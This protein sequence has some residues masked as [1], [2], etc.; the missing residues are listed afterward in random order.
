[1]PRSCIPS[2]VGFGQ[3]IVE[4]EFVRILDQ[5]VLARIAGGMAAGHAAGMLPAFARVIPMEAKLFEPLTDGAGGRD[6][7]FQ[8]DPFADDLGLPPNLR[9]FVFQFVQQGKRIGCAYLVSRIH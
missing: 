8:R 5:I 4:R 6:V 3:G 7:E 9:Q 1:M 2:R